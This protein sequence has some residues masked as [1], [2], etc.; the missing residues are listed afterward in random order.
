VLRSA[1]PMQ[2]RELWFTGPGQVELRTGD[3]P[4][5]RPGMVLVRSIASGVSQGT[6]L[7]LFN[8][9]GT[10]PFDPSLGHEGATYPCRY[11]YS[12]VGEVIGRADDVSCVTLGSRIFALAPHGDIHLLRSNQVRSIS[13]AI[14]APRAVLAANLETAVNC[15]W[16]SGMSVGD[17]VAILGAGTV[18][19]LIAWLSAKTGA[20]VKVIEPSE[21]RRA[22]ATKF[23][24]TSVSRSADDPLVG[25]ADIVIEASG[26]PAAL[27]SAIALAGREALIV[28]VSNYGRRNSSVDLG[29]H[30]HRRRLTIKSS[31]VS[32]IP[33]DRAPRWSLDRR[34]E[35]VK[36]LLLDQQLD[37]LL[38]NIIDFNRAAET[39]EKLRDLPGEYVQTVFAY[40]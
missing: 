11:G 39:Y 9:E 34:F 7:L 16:D 30:F 40:S 32:A 1:P 27:D 36:R 22:V 14:P 10:E 4:R 23:G 26:N 29:N 31:Q 8:G 37:T 19:L 24:V 18:G 3:V 17:R 5:L 33:A 2:T 20:D 25:A 6:E 35:L 15:V 12:C 38:D 13:P 21:K 28:V